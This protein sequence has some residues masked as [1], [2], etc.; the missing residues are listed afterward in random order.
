MALVLAP[1]IIIGTAF[2]VSVMIAADIEKEEK[3]A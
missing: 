1:M 2:A 3:E